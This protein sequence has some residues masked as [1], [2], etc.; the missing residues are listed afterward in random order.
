MR[1]CALAFDVQPF[2]ARI[3]GRVWAR[4]GEVP[5]W[6][7]CTARTKRPKRCSDPLDS[8]QMKTSRWLPV[9]G[10]VKGFD[11]DGDIEIF[12]R[13]FRYLKQRCEP[14]FAT[15]HLRSRELIDSTRTC[16]NA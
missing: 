7:Q 10:Y 6:T 5:E 15:L 2:V 12:D 1:R 3:D 11:Y 4:P 8:G 9:K 16:W 14:R 13:R